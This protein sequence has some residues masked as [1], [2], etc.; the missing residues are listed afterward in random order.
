MRFD[1]RSGF[2]W[3]GGMEKTHY[4]VRIHGAHGAADSLSE[5]LLSMMWKQLADDQH[6]HTGGLVVSDESA[7][8]IQHRIAA[9]LTWPAKCLVIPI[10]AD[11]SPMTRQQLDEALQAAAQAGTWSVG[12]KGRPQGQ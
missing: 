12:Q 3:D 2:G 9:E 8:D 7:Q 10:D 1:V 11:S 4:L 6:T 5:L